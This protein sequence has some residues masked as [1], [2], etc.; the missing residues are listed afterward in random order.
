MDK[1]NGE[2]DTL[3]VQE[4]RNFL[5]DIG[6]QGPIEKAREI[7]FRYS[8]NNIELLVNGESHPL[9]PQTLKDYLAE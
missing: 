8:G 7:D 5:K 1:V 2:D 4:L 9:E 6:Y 3:T